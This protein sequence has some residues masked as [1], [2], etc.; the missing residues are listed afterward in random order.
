MT[1]QMERGGWPTPF[2]P[3]KSGCP[4]LC[5]A[6][7]AQLRVGEKTSGAKAP[8]ILGPLFAGLKTRTTSV[9]Q[10]LK[11]APLMARYGTAKAVP[12][13]LTMGRDSRVAGLHY[14][15]RPY[16]TLIALPPTRH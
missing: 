9:P 12:L 10:G 14:L 8:N 2:T 15:S 1:K 16:R 7:V 11:P 3:Y 5:C 6:G 4:V 13:P